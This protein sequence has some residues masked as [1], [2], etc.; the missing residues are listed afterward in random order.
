MRRGYC[1]V[2]AGPKPI[3]LVEAGRERL[4][5]I[6]G[7]LTPQQSTWSDR[8]GVC[9]LQL[10]PN[11]QR[12]VESIWMSYA[13]IDERLQDI[14]T[15]CR[16]R[17]REA[18]GYFDLLPY[19]FHVMVYP[20]HGHPPVLGATNGTDAAAVSVPGNSTLDAATA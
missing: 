13:D 8:T 14:I 7:I 11:D 9:G 10:A 19:S 1:L 18:G 17:G 16:K 20:L 2:S 15:T 12:H 6:G 3:S 4:F 5:G